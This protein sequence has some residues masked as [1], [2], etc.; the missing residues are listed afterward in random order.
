VLCSRQEELS[1]LLAPPL[2]T[3]FIRTQTVSF[4]FFSFTLSLLSL[5]LYYYYTATLPDSL[6]SMH[7][8][9]RSV[10]ASEYSTIHAY[11]TLT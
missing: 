8:S 11:H 1:L 7:V 5:L 3:R 4:Y 2:H 6:H 10:G 9:R